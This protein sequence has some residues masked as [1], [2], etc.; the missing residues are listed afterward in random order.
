MKMTLTDDEIEFLDVM[1]KLS[2][3]VRA[4]IV[5]LMDSWIQRDHERKN[6]NKVIRF[7]NKNKVKIE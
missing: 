4:R 2:P 6:T 7:P 1:R 3:E 5:R